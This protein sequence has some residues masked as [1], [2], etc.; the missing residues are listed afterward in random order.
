MK[1]ERSK[2]HRIECPAVSQ[3]LETLD[4]KAARI[5]DPKVVYHADHHHRLMPRLRAQEK[6]TALAGEIGYFFQSSAE[7]KV[8]LQAMVQRKALLTFGSNHFDALWLLIS[9]QNYF[10]KG[11]FG[12]T[13]IQSGLI[14]KIDL[15]ER[16][17][18][19]L[20]KSC[21]EKAF[22]MLHAEGIAFA[23]DR[24]KGWTTHYDALQRLLRS[25]Q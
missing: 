4:I 1:L 19:S 24:L 15:E 2:F 6:E 8:S 25:R 9:A 5:D 3:L 13:L 18:P 12:S 20:Q 23:W 16:L 7:Y 14:R 21:Y 10:E 17:N 11:A 22:L